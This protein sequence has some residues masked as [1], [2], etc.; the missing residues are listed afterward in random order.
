MFLEVK[1]SEEKTSTFNLYVYCRSLSVHKCIMPT[2]SY[3]PVARWPRLRPTPPRTYGPFCPL[4]SRHASCTSIAVSSSFGTLG[5]LK[6]YTKCTH[7]CGSYDP[8]SVRA[9]S[10]IDLDT[11]KLCSQNYGTYIDIYFVLH[12]VA[13][14]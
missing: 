13:R 14:L 1:Y 6:N 12:Y 2:S 4:V 9:D 10:F 3:R 5:E 8:P 11:G 7:K